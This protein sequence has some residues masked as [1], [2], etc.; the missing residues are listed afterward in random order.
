[1]YFLSKNAISLLKCLKDSHSK[2]AE[3]I[4]HMIILQLLR[5]KS[6]AVN[7]SVQVKLY[8]WYYTISAWS[9]DKMS[10]CRNHWCM[11]LKV[12]VLSLRKSLCG[13]AL[14]QTLH[15]F[16]HA[17]LDIN[18]LTSIS[19]KNLTMDLFLICLIDSLYCCWVKKDLWRVIGQLFLLCFWFSWQDTNAKV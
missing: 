11:I 17:M 16:Q 7:F 1:M 12:M 4:N 15:E 9:M 5:K 6:A 3:L 10:N 2:V 8:N 18:A 13:Q 19:I 14:H